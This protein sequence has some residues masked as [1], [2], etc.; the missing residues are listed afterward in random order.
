MPMPN[1]CFGKSSNFR[2]AMWLRAARASRLCPGC[3]DPLTNVNVATGC[4]AFRHHSPFEVA[5]DGDPAI[6]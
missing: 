3:L 5:S 1:G 4:V 2:N 6:R